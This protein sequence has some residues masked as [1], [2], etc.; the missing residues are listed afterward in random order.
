MTIF[1]NGMGGGIGRFLWPALEKLGAVRLASRPGPGTLVHDLKTPPERD[2]VRFARGDI[3]VFLAALSKPGDCARNP[4]EAWRIN[5]ENTGAL[6]ERALLAGASVLFFSS[7]TVY[8]NQDGLLDESAPLKAEEP[9]GRMKAAV[10]TRFSGK[11]GFAALRL[12]YVVS[13]TDGVTA[14]LK[15]CARTGNTA[16]VF[17]G[18]ARNMVGVQDVVETVLTLARLAQAGRPLPPAVNLA[19]ERCVTRYEMATAYRDAVAPHLSI[20]EIPAPEGFFSARP[21][22][23]SLDVSL[24]TSL[25]RR[26]PQ[27]LIEVYRSE[28]LKGELQNG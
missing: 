6:V 7:D 16:E 1:A 26:P 3:L 24:L 17:A 5:V 18:Y 27:S 21:K 22:K 14:Y 28:I 11:P 13:R 12:S 4:G 15:E 19:G 20:R 2:V 23:I 25:M 9:Y 10:E 8:G